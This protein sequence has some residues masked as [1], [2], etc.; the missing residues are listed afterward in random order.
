M[1]ASGRFSADGQ[2]DV[3]RVRDAADIVRIVGEYVRLK[4]A[5]REFKGLCPF[6]DDH[7]PSMAVVPHKG[8]F[9]CFVC[10]A[11]GDSIAFVRRYLKMEFR[12]AL[13]FLAEK[14]GVQLTPRRRESSDRPEVAGT[15]RQDLL[16]AN[17]VAAGF[18]RTLLSH[19]EHGAVARRVVEKRG[20]LPEISER[21]LLG[22]SPGADR[23]DGLQQYIRSKGLLESTFA[24]A[25]LLKQRESGGSYDA[26]R[27][28]LM[29]PIQDAGGRVIAFGARRLDDADEP[30]YLNS[31][32]T[33]LFVK[34]ATL[35]GLNHASK[36][37]QK[38]RTAILTEGYMDT[39][40]CHQAGVENAVAALGTS[41]TREH[42][43]VLR[44]FCTRVVLLFDGDDAGQ[45]AADRAVEVFF[46]EPLDVKIATLKTWT[47]AK[48][49]DE[50]LKRE[51]GREIFDRAIDKAEDLL[52]YRFRRLRANLE[53][54]GIAAVSQG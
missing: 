34:K 13:E 39:I 52:T 40:A 7:N 25:G 35:Y 22:T 46:A 5:G 48:D 6:H 54:G 26:F 4:P 50:L 24:E 44:R 29:F 30:K 28:R 47:D 42:A 45:R 31:P 49:P 38:E 14:L 17:A 16:K 36:A 51:G 15:S 11:G 8:I 2:D 27:N 53:G 37:I 1:R 23:W 20:I 33:R 41:L 19:P 32:E 18:Y 3:A 12:E 10:G 43:A 9:H 21:F